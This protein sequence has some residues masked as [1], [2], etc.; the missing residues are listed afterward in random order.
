MNN[1]KILEDVYKD[2]FGDNRYLLKEE[3]KEE[4]SDISID[5]TFI[6]DESKLLLKKIVKYMED[7]NNEKE[8]NYLTFNLII[9]TDDRN[10]IKEV[11]DYI[12]YYALKYNYIDKKSYKKL[13]LYDIKNEEDITSI[14][15]E[16]G[17]IDIDD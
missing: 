2:F 6:D 1:K 9:E 4:A 15:N 16:N 14:Y 5:N 11:S 13:S 8:K 3:Q 12:K 10:I 7:Y 17:I